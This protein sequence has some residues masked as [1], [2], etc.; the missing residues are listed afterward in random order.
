MRLPIHG[1]TH[2][3]NSM[4]PVMPCASST[5]GPPFPSTRVWAPW[6][7]PSQLVIAL[8]PALLLGALEPVLCSGGVKSSVGVPVTTRPVAV[9][10]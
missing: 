3:F 2:F 6:T 5:S 8:G 10:A 4:L 7:A 1:A 9:S